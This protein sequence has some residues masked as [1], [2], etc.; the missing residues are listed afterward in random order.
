MPGDRNHNHDKTQPGQDQEI[1]QDN[2]Q[3]PGELPGYSGEQKERKK[4]L[5][6]VQKHKTT[7]IGP[8]NKTKNNPTRSG[9]W[10]DQKTKQNRVQVGDSAVV[11]CTHR[12]QVNGQED[13]P[14]RSRAQKDGREAGRAE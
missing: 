7:Q 3:R 1:D 10:T 12:V 4:Y 8:G 5:K 2:D 9:G 13:V 11:P 14:A 6:Q